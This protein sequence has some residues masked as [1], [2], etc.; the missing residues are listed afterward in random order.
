MKGSDV[1]R[2]ITLS[3][4]S[5]G[6]NALVNQLLEDIA[7]VCAERVAVVITENVPDDTALRVPTAFPAKTIVNREVKGFGANHNAAFGHCHTPYFCIA[8]PDI[9][10]PAD[11]FPALLGAVRDEHVGAVGPLV[12]S[13]QGTVEDS[14]R[15]F[16]TPAILLRKLVADRR[17][18]DYPT[19]A[20]PV[21]VDWVAGMF[22]VL[23]R[24]AFA[25][26]R[27]FDEAYF[28][29]YEDV[30]LCYRLRRLGKSI[31]W[32][33]IAEIVHNARRDSRRNIALAMHHWA[34]ALRFLWRAR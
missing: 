8:N 9:R 14:A 7:R 16:P 19:G 18:P 17:A 23:R 29:Y 25:A 3:V 13:P 34:S 4:I 30:D 6:Q 28:L 15:R 21:E 2:D 22:I 31:C 32:H 10:L 33:P 11:P 20:D 5:H 1:P 26:V 27:G 24:D 12:R